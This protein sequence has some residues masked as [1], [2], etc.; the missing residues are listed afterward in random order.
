LAATRPGFIRSS[1]P[2]YP[3]PP[4]QPKYNTNP[5]YKT[6]SELLTA[7]AAVTP[8]Q[9]KVKK[10]DI[11]SDEE[12][13][14]VFAAP[15]IVQF[16]EETK[17]IQD[18]PKV[19]LLASVEERA[20]Q[21]LKMKPYELAKQTELSDF[22]KKELLKMSIQR[23][24]DA[25]ST[26]QMNGIS[27]DKRAI[28]QGENTS[29]VWLLRIVKLITQGIPTTTTTIEPKEEEIEEED[30]KMEITEDDPNDLKELLLNYILGNLSLR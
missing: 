3:P 11:D 23:I 1:T 2:P 22:E 30:T 17:I 26:F 13:E 14:N 9:V 4:E 6:E 25:E 24:F 27:S 15:P 28:T 18:K 12:M 8:Q 10:E 21:A 5:R 7:A 20:S 29:S 19:Q 16:K